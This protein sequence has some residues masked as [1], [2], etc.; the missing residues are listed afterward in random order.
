MQGEN[1]PCPH[2]GRETKRPGHGGLPLLLFGILVV[3][4]LIAAGILWIICQSAQRIVT[5][6]PQRPSKFS[7]LIR[8]VEKIQS[9]AAQYDEARRIF[10]SWTDL[11][12]A[13]DNF[14]ADQYNH[15]LGIPDV[16]GSDPAQS[17]L[18][19]SCMDVYRC[20][21]VFNIDC[22]TMAAGDSPA[23]GV[24]RDGEHHADLTNSCALLIQQLNK[25]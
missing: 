9:L 23:D 2:C 13:I 3:L 21:L 25:Q 18:A 7:D 22:S 16:G 8:D 17:N 19:C 5:V 1:V 10:P 6:Q 20:A 12:P 11:G 15:H 14:K 4:C 24:W